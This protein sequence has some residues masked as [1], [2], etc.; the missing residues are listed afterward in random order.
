V[1]QRESP[2]GLFAAAVRATGTNHREGLPFA[3][4]ES[5]RERRA[6]TFLGSSRG[7]ENPKKSSEGAAAAAARQARQGRRDAG[8]S[9]EADMPPG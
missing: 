7:R 6:A 3:S 5:A 8:Q 2:L 1:E 4:F 9:A